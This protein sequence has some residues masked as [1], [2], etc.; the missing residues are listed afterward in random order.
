M[1]DVLVVTTT[2]G[3]V[4]GVH[5]NTTSTR[6]R[7]AL[8]AHGVV[9]ATGLEEG[10]VDT[11]TAGGDTD[12]STGARRDSLLRARRETDAGLA[13]L[14]VANDGGVVA[15]GAGEGS[16]VTDLLLDVED[17]GTLGAR[18][19]GDNVAD[20]ESGLLAGVDERAGRD[21]LGR[22]EGLLA[23]LVAVRVTED[24]GREGSTTASVVDD[25]ANDTTDVPVLLG[26]VE[27]A[28]ASGVLVVVRVG[29]EDPTR[30]PL[31]TNDTLILVS[32]QHGDFASERAREFEDVHP[33]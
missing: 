24:D 6:P 8:G 9:L 28:V 21:A 2:V 4:D 31:G 10:L 30:L 27:V 18:A 3:V 25:L 13:V 12:G 5:G 11:A 29:L 23:E 26:E 7:V 16:T 19:E 20:R 33:C 17:N 22:N 15:R 14:R 32:N 1:T